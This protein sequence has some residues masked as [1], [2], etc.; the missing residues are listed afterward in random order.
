MSLHCITCHSLA[1]LDL[2][3]AHR[4]ISQGF[5]TDLLHPLHALLNSALIESLFYCNT[6]QLK[7]S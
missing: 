2:S 4:M 7:F 1:A 3:T 6:W 5:F